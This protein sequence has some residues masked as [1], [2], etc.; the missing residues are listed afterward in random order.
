MLSSYKHEPQITFVDCDLQKE[1]VLNYAHALFA[2]RFFTAKDFLVSTAELNNATTSVDLAHSVLSYP[3]F[4]YQNKFI[5]KI[6]IRSLHRPDSQDQ[7]ARIVQSLI[8]QS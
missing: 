7:I 1:C 6:A 8:R 5:E 2:D 3:T 4:D